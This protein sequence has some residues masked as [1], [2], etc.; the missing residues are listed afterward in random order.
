[1]DETERLE[2]DARIRKI[3]GTR[4]ND[5]TDIIGE[6]AN[7]YLSRGT[8]CKLN[9]DMFDAQALRG[10]TDDYKAWVGQHL[11]RT[12]FV[13]ERVSEMLFRLTDDADIPYKW[14]FRPEDLLVED[15]DHPGSF[16]SPFDLESAN[17][18]ARFGNTAEEKALIKAAMEELK[19]NYIPQK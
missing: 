12:F 4:F 6:M 5:S 8:K 17:Y 11:S 16:V 9:P 15:P 7:D 2:R 19:K 18:M 10:K 14:F 3:L 13:G 1:M